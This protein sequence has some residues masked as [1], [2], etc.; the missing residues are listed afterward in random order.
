DVDVS[1]GTKGAFG[2]G[3]GNASYTLVI[4]PDPDSTGTI[5][6]R[7]E[8]NVATDAAGNGNERGL[9]FPSEQPYDTSST[10]RTLVIGELL[11]DAGDDTG[12]VAN[13]GTADDPTPELT[14][15]M[16]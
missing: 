2:G 13:G 3:P 5:S 8:E 14:V 10:G 6:V 1:G 16:S 12:P 11:D 15:T 4:A 9:P 7:V